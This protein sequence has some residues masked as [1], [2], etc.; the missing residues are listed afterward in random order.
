M[1]RVDTAS[2]VVTIDGPTPKAVKKAVDAVEKVQEKE[3]E[4]RAAAE[5][6]K[7]ERLEREKAK[8]RQERR[9][10]EVNPHRCFC[11]ETAEG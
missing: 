11:G 4:E 6:R 5:E 3:R 9:A 7:S 1:V 2:R 10:A 8:L